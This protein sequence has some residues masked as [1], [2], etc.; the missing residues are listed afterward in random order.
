MRTFADFSRGTTTWPML[1]AIQRQSL[2]YASKG[3]DMLKD[4][5]ML[6][7]LAVLW[8]F[9]ESTLSEVRRGVA[10]VRTGGVNLYREVRAHLPVSL[11]GQ[12]NS[13][14]YSLVHNNL[15]GRPSS[16]VLHRYHE[17]GLTQ[18]CPVKYGFEGK[19]CHSVL[20]VD[21]NAL[22][23]YC[24]MQDMPIGEP[25]KTRWVEEGWR[26]V[27]VSEWLMAG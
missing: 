2:V 11:V 16:I 23:L 9:G 14:L 25:I 17:A 19:L 13:D 21:A 3:I 27:G 7:G 20:G 1:C 24:M 5:T 4:G 22:Y 8:L 18:I 15:V 26:K 12:S 6:P 10:P